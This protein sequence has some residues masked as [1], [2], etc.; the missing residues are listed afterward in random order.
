MSIV[1][2][3]LVVIAFGLAVCFLLAVI[4]VAMNEEPGPRCG[5][6]IYFDRDL[7]ICWKNNGLPS[8]GEYDKSCKYFD[9]EEKS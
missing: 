9:K 3:F 7:R 5:R 1:L 8:K 6:C 2:A 4:L